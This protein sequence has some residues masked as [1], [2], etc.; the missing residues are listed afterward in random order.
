M[1]IRS[2]FTG[3][4]S[5]GTYRVDA[6]LDGVFDE[7]DT[8]LHKNLYCVIGPYSFSCGNLVPNIFKAS[9]V[10]TLLGKTSGGGSCSVLPLSTAYG[11][12]FNISSPKRF[13][14]MK[15][16]SYYDTDTG[17]EPDCII[18]RPESFYNR[19][20]LTDYINQLF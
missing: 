13:S 1:S 3:A 5:T 20:A 12:M 4:T 14:Y 18:T 9:G 6:N 15:N 19:Q 8:L 17:I 10:V 16:G 7:N 11:T 2:S